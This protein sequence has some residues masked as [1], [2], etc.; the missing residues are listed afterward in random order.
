MGRSAEE[1]QQRG[2]AGPL[3]P[4]IPAS[5]VHVRGRVLLHV[6]LLHVLLHLQEEGRRGARAGEHSDGRQ[7]QLQPVHLPAAGHVRHDRH[8]D[9]VRRPEPDLRLVV[10]DASRSVSSRRGGDGEGSGESGV[11][12]QWYW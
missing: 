11:T 6:R 10:P 4:S 5:N 12:G 2:R 9:H 7:P 1:H 3:Q 8:L